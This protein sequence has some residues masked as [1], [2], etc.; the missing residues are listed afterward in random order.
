MDRLIVFAGSLLAILAVYALVRWLRLG[1]MA[2]HDADDACRMA[3][4]GLP[5][6]TGEDAIVSSDGMAA[7]VKGVD[8]SFALIKCHGAHP[9][10]RA[11]PQ[12]TG[13][14]TGG[15]GDHA[16]RID[17]GDRAFGA[18]WL[19]LDKSGEDKLLTWM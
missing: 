19:A 14:Q 5:G 3:R 1:D 13:V 10:I 9:A 8:G 11:M 2:I 17:C 16:V 7:L 15:S 4:Q 6:F 18:V 12:L